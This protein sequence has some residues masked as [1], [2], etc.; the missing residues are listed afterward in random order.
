MLVFFFLSERDVTP[1]PSST[2]MADSHLSTMNQQ[3][4]RRATKGP[5]VC[6]LVLWTSGPHVSVC[7]L[8][9]TSAMAGV[10]VEQVEGEF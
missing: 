8:P 4:D 10:R 2:V 9:A 1:L 7:S 5:A 6:E 3:V